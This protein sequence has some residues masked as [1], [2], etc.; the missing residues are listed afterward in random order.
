[1]SE[2]YTPETLEKGARAVG[3]AFT[4]QT[5]GRLVRQADRVA[6]V[7]A[8]LDAVAGDLWDEGYRAGNLDG[9]SGIRAMRDGE[10]GRLSHQAAALTAIAWAV[11]A[12]VTWQVQ[13]KGE[14]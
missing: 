2:N 3:D 14:A 4:H 1:M 9:Y 13:G 6:I 10:T 11:C 8:V 12:W 5:S 7:G